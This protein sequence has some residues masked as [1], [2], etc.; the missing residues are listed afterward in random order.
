M[1]FA[2]HLAAKFIKLEA[3]EKQA[4]ILFSTPNFIQIANR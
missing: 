3:L 2:S 4:I 1:I